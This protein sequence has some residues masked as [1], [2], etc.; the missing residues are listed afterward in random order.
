MAK[1]RV[2]NK[3]PNGLTHVEMFRG[4]KIEIPANK[5]H[6]MDYED[7]VQFKGQFYPMKKRPT[8]EPDPSSFK[9]LFLQ[10]HDGETT[11]APTRF[12][13]PIDGKEFS[14]Q[15]DLDQYIKREYSDVPVL[16][17][18]SAEREIAAEAMRRGPGRPPK[19]KEQ[20]V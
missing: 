14:T 15:S 16:V 7:A 12:I 4:E 18:E 9:V 10:P 8:G 6:I 5:Y 11:P 17:D 19:V 13:C 3:H 20:A 2:W 1:W